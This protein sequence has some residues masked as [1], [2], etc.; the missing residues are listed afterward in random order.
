MNY[1][2]AFFAL[3]VNVPVALSV[4]F[5]RLVNKTVRNSRLAFYEP[6]AFNKL[7]KV[8]VNSRLVHTFPALRKK[9]KQLH[10]RKSAFRSFLNKLRNQ[11]R[12]FGVVRFL[13]YGCILTG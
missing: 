8:A 3:K 1:R 13:Q 5:R 12:S 11:I 4:F 9:G 10:R 2:A 6:P 7:V